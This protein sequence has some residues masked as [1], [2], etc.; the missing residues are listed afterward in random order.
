VRRLRAW[1]DQLL[2]EIGRQSMY[3]P[4]LE[5]RRSAR[6]LHDAMTRREQGQ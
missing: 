5:A 6:E 1:I 3:D 4:R 2:S